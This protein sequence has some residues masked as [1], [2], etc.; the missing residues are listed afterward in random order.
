[1]D[2]IKEQHA[3]AIE[4]LTAKEAEKKAEEQG[5]KGQ[6]VLFPGP[7]KGSYKEDGKTLA[8]ALF[9]AENL[10]VE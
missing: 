5:A 10:Q 4:E 1:M 7:V 2:T 6:A 9:K 3:K 8:P